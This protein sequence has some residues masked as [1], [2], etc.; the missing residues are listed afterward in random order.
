VAQRTRTQSREKGEVRVSD[1]FF[2]TYVDDNPGGG[3]QQYVTGG[4]KDALLESG[5]A[6]TIVGVKF[7]EKGGYD[8]ADRFVLDV[9]LA[10]EERKLT[11]QAGSVDSRDRMLAAMAEFLDANAGATVNAKLEAS[12][13]ATLVSAAA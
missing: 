10:G 11:F 9:I 1:D 3:G 6:F 13:R 4:E 12:G 7:D 2:G 8:N 5:D